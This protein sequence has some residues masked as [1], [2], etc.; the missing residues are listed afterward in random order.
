M[1]VY[2]T[3]IHSP[4]TNPYSSISKNLSD[5]VKRPNIV[6]SGHQEQDAIKQ[7]AILLCQAP[8]QDVVKYRPGHQGHQYAYMTVDTIVAV[9]NSVWGPEGWTF[10]IRNKQVRSAQLVQDQRNGD[11]IFQV[12]VTSEVRVTIIESGAFKDGSATA[13]ARNTEEKQAWDTAY[14]SADSNALKR[15]LSLF[16]EYLSL[17]L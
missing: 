7:R 2:T 12:M 1:S 16:G 13:T 5:A 8:R 15:A 6:D 17:G 9:A 10:E 14:K 3:Y 11:P 4:N